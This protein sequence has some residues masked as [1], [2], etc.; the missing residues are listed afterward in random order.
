MS[1]AGAHRH[2]GAVIR[3]VVFDLDGVL[4]ES[5][6]LW[7]DA[8]HQ[9]VTEE[10]GQWSAHA[11]SAMQGMSS[12]EWS[13]Y[14]HD[15]LAVQLDTGRIVD[16][17]VDKLLA[18]YQR[19]LPLVAGAVEAVRRLAGRWPLGLA[20][21]ADRVV[22]DR[23]LALAGLGGFFAVTVLSEEVDRGKPAPDVYLEAAPRLAVAA[24]TC[25][26]VED[27][28]NGVRSALSAGMHVVVVPNR[29][30]QPPADVLAAADG[31]VHSLDELTVEVVE[32]LDDG[33]PRRERRLDEEEV[34]SFPASDSHSDWAGPDLGGHGAA[35]PVAG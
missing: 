2:T 6:P 30:F 1:P 21:S 15:K 32:Y 18:R 24:D 4:L 7:D 5:E 20:S 8:R 28:A 22:I 23:V 14:M 35:S 31:V 11:T 27:S 13:A 10:G 25:V 34:E 12:P 33:V 17:V 3:A 26:A 29:D 19:G 9:V 16:L